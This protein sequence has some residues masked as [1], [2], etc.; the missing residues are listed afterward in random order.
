MVSAINTNQYG[1]EQLEVMRRLQ[2]LGVS[3]SGNLSVDRQRLQKA[4]Y[5]KLQQTLSVSNYQNLSNLEGSG[6]SF[7][8]TLNSVNSNNTPELKNNDDFSRQTG[9]TQLAEL[10]RYQFGL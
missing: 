7:S 5:T 9:A 3:P 1:Y 10:N 4:E 2:S 8:D 6:N